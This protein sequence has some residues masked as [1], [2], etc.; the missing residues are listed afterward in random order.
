MF[1]CSQLVSYPHCRLGSAN[2]PYDPNVLFRDLFFLVFSE[3]TTSKDS[4][5]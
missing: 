5:S 4:V 2:V 3:L 1:A